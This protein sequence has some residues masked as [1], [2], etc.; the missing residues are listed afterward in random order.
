M[1]ELDIGI[2]IGIPLQLDATLENGMKLSELLLLLERGSPLNNMP[3]RPIRQIMLDMHKDEI[4]KAMASATGC[5]MGGYKERAYRILNSVA[6]KIPN[7]IGEIIGNPAFLA[8]N[9]LLT[10]KHKGGRNTPLVDTGRLKRSIKGYVIK[11]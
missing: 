6:S 4:G 9:S 3:P 8:S 11:E 2:E 7:W 5:M 1:E 10:I